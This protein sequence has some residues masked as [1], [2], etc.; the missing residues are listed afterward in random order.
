MRLFDYFFNKQVLKQG[1]HFFSTLLTH[2]PS[3]LVW[4]DCLPLCSITLTMPPSTF[5]KYDQIHLSTVSNSN[6]FLYL[7]YNIKTFSAY[8]D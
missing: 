4:K 2:I 3:P 6:P 8:A 1:W 5:C 7:F